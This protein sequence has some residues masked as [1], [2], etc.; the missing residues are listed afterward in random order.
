MLPF[1][2]RPDPDE[3]LPKLLCLNTIWGSIAFC[4]RRSSIISRR[5][6]CPQWSRARTPSMHYRDNGYAPS[7]ASVKLL[8][9]DHVVGKQLFR[10]V[11]D[12]MH[13]VRF[14]FHAGSMS[15]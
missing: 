8:R 13:G 7:D 2:E 4:Y 15:Q 11:T 9:S 5:N 12:F 6:G 14:D 10:V 1:P 3:R